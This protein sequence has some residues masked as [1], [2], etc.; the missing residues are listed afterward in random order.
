MMQ[1]LLSNFI[2]ELVGLRRKI[3]Q[4]CY[5]VCIRCTQ[6]K[7]GFKMN[8][9]DYQDGDEAGLK[10]VTFE[11]DGEK[12]YGLLKSEHGVHRLVRISPFDSNAR[13]H[14]SFCSC[15]VTPK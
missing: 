13:R 9:L 11:V 2:Q 4:K 10:S 3:G 6:R 12:A 8:V 5:F 7:K 14:T 1:V 15:S